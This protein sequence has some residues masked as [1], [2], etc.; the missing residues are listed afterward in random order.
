M[1]IKILLII[2]GVLIM[3]K[4]SLTPQFLSV[5]IDMKKSKSLAYPCALVLTFLSFLLVTN[6]HGQ[7]EKESPDE[8]V[9]T[10]SC[11]EL[12]VHRITESL[13]VR[14]NSSRTGDRLYYNLAFFS[15]L[16]P[17]AI[18]SVSIIV[19]DGRNNHVASFNVKEHVFEDGAKNYIF[20][21]AEDYT[22]NSSAFIRTV[23]KKGVTKGMRFDF[24]SLMRHL[25]DGS[26]K[27]SD[28]KHKETQK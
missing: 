22:K 24:K 1:S 9:W 10:C 14:I 20:S 17:D 19:C 27:G 21:V 11:K 28:K 6:T 7:L 16:G 12:G 2:N 8:I 4:A 26:G 3:K 25:S 13:S 5:N 18:K 15:P 23:D